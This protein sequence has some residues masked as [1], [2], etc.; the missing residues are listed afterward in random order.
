[1]AL[2]PT[3]LLK[4]R[5]DYLL[6]IAASK[7]KAKAKSATKAASKATQ[8]V[9]TATKAVQTTKSSAAIVRMAVA[10][11][12]RPPVSMTPISAA[13]KIAIEKTL[14]T[15]SAADLRVATAAAAAKGK[16]DGA[17]IVD[18]HKVAKAE[19]KVSEDVIKLAVDK[20]LADKAAAEAKAILDAKA[21]ADAKA[22][23]AATIS[24]APPSPP[25]KLTSVS[26]EQTGKETIVLSWTF[27]GTRK[28]DSVKIYKRTVG[29]AYLLATTA[30]GETAYTDTKANYLTES[31]HFLVFNPKNL[32]VAKE[33][34]SISVP[35]AA[36]QARLK[37]E[38]D[39]LNKDKATW[40]SNAKVWEDKLKR[41]Q[42]AL[43]Y[44]DLHP[45]KGW[46]GSMGD[47]IKLLGNIS[48]TKSNLKVAKD[49]VDG[50]SKIIAEL[51][52]KIF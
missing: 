44:S 43:E 32:L 48:S 42:E 33:Y 17:S 23:A 49:K 41:L 28:N 1:M 9:K 8:T 45:Y 39:A 19:I 4:L 10:S 46:Y 47:R 12:S 7:A 51:L 2:S 34:N 40:E 30:P 52:K 38:L 35:I 20:A 27:Y 50:I 5:Q 6:K 31:Y 25:P 15:M 26:W 36:T 22:K 14:K 37:S 24:E 29:P 18:E 11:S 16:R 3:Q 13:E 21:A